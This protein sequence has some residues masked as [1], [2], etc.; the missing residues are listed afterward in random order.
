MCNGSLNLMNVC[1]SIALGR[2][3]YDVLETMVP[4]LH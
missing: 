4:I 1:V 2:F 3:V